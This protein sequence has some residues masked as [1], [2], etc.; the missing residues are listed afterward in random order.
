MIKFHKYHG[1][2][3]DF[4]LFNS[5]SDEGRLPEWLTPQKIQYLCRR[6]YG[7]GGDGV[8]VLASSVKA[9]FYMK[10]FN[11][12]GSEAELSGNGLRCLA[13]FIKELGLCSDKSFTVE[14]SGGLNRLEI[15]GDNRVRVWMPKPSYQPKD[16]PILDT[17][18][19]VE[20]KMKFGGEIFTITALSIGNPH[21]VIFNDFNIVDA[22]KWGSVIEESGYFPQRTNV[23]FARVFGKDRIG[24]IVWERG[25]GITDACGSGACAAAIAAVKTGRLEFNKMTTVEQIGGSLKVIIGE[26]FQEVILEGEAVK[27]FE[28]KVDL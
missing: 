23:E 5:N 24:V 14:T 1:L 2:G 25:V 12:D 7:I 11:A 6:K 10:L 26:N 8:I 15:V 21:C 13:L 16:I 9:D 20:R 18:I 4:I 19:C 27:V 22:E 3:N 28:G 17:D